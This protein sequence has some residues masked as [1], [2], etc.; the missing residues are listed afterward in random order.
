MIAASAMPAVLDAL[1]AMPQT[2]KDNNFLDVTRQPL[3]KIS[4]FMLKNRPDLLKE[5]P[6]GYMPHPA[7]GPMRIQ[8]PA[9][10]FVVAAVG[11]VTVVAI[12]EYG[13]D[14][15]VKDL[16]GASGKSDKSGGGLLDAIFRTT[17]IGA[18]GK[19]TGWF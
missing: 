8:V 6:T 16:K 5:F 3:I 19:A 15:L 18:V 13:V 7:W 17:P 10:L 1:R 2:A 14:N 4:K 9:W 12:L 11:G